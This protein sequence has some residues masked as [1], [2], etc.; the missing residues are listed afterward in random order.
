D[1]PVEQVGI[2][3]LSVMGSCLELVLLKTQGGAS[4]VRRGAAH[5]LADPGRQIGKIL[6]NAP[7]AGCGSLVQP[8]Q[9]AERLPFILNKRRCALPRSRFQQYNADTLLA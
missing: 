1:G 7:G 2:L 9:L 8:R 3:E 4:P 6:G 5:C